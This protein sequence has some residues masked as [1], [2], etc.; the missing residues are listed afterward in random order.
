ML[1]GDD[2]CRFTMKRRSGAER[3][4]NV[5]VEEKRGTR[6]CSIE[7]KSCAQGKEKFKE[8]LIPNRIKAR[9]TWIICRSLEDFLGSDN[10]RKSTHIQFK[11]GPGFSSIRQKYLTT[12][13]SM[14]WV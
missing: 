8:M 3:S 14:V 13:T 10:N 4:T 9:P 1:I 11:R 2:L 5:Q 12:S 6:E 7:A